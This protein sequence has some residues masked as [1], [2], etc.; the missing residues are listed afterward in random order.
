MFRKLTLLVMTLAIL[1]SF[2]GVAAAQEEIR[3]CISVESDYA[4]EGY[5]SANF[6]NYDTGIKRAQQFSESP[7]I[8]NGRM[9]VP[10]RQL[11]ESL[12]YGVMWEQD[13]QAIELTGKNLKGEDTSIKMNVGVSQATVNSKSIP[14]DA[15]PK[16]VNGHTMIPLRFISKNSNL[17]DV[18]WSV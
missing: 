4:P 2:T 16:I 12:G 7:V 15:S 9:L 11:A 3:V 10:L 8:E 6:F 14:I 17:I 18:Y 1:L 5:W 13:T